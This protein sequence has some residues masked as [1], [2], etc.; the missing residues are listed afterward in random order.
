MILPEKELLTVLDKV[1][2]MQLDQ[3]SRFSFVPA[4]SGVSVDVRWR[5]L[6]L[7]VKRIAL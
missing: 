6:I 3:L 2:T 7:K 5:F 1:S 4:I